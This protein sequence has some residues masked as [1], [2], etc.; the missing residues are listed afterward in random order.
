MMKGCVISSANEGEYHSLF[1][2]S[3]VP[4][5]KDS[6]INSLF[7]AWLRRNVQDRGISIANALEI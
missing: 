3:P 2:L 1:L 6:H 4:Q 5:K 7:I